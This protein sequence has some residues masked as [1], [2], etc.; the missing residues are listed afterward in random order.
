MTTPPPSP[1]QLLLVGE[2]AGSFGLRGQLKLRSYTDAPDHL[3]R[4]VRVLYVGPN[5]TAYRMLRAAEHKAEL[6]ILTLD[7]IT[8][9]EQADALTRA[10]VFIL[11]TDAAP[12]AED[13][14]FIHQLYGLKVFTDTGEELGTVREVLVTGANEVLVV[15]RP[16]GEVLVPMIHDVVRELDISGGRIVIH[17]LEGML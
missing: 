4:N 13:E 16:G 8:T 5:R 11:E 12:L 7:G 1:D 2:F 3:R 10:E 9:R 6:F 14:Y 15:P 17:P